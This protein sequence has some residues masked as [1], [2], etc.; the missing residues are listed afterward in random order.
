MGYGIQE[1]QTE[2]LDCFPLSVP[3]AGI[4]GVAFVLPESPSLATRRSDRVYLKR[5]LL[6]EQ[7]DGLLPEWA[8]F[9]RCVINATGLKPN[10]SREAFQEDALF[11]KARAGLAACLRDYL[12]ELARRDRPRLQKLIGIHF[13]AIKVL[14]ADDEAFYRLFIDWLPFETSHGLLPMGKIRQ[15]G[16]EVLYVPNI[17]TFRQ[18][19][20]VAAAQAL[21]LINAGYT[22]DVDLIERLPEVFPELTV[23]RIAPEDLLE[24]M[25]EVPPA[26]S[27]VV[28][29][30]LAAMAEALDRFECD[31]A[32]RCFRPAEL[33][34]L[35]SLDRRRAFSGICGAAGSSRTPC[36]K[37][38][39]PASGRSRRR[40]RADACA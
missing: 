35:Y 30:Q 17:D 2:F 29:P 3:E 21:C 23:R 8:F 13:R 19:S 12:M 25:E 37:I 33:A 24:A 40:A 28:E 27:A 31:V 10:A 18:L 16:T 7:A 34:A 39:C 22:C 38:C 4:Q 5:M 9:V 32:I 26:E 15:A 1:F 6:S 20:A 36:F 11:E 14:A